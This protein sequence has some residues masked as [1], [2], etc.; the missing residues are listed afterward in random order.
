VLLH[1]QNVLELAHDTHWFASVSSCNGRQTNHLG[2]GIHRESRICHQFIQ[3]TCRLHQLKTHNTTEQIES[4]TSNHA[5]SETHDTWNTQSFLPHTRDTSFNQ[6]QSM[7][8][9]LMKLTSVAHGQ[10]SRFAMLGRFVVET[11]NKRPNRS[12]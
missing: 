3:G 12:H 6:L 5:V 10:K 8:S 11:K 9:P 4:S 2:H 1:L 7:D